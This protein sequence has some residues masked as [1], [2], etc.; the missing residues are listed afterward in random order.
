[1]EIYIKPKKRV[2]LAGVDAVCVSDVADVYAGDGLQK[3]VENIKLLR[4]KKDG[5]FLVASIDVVKAIDAALPGHTV[6]NLGE[7]DCVIEYRCKLPKERSWLLWIKVAVVSMVLFVGASTA[8]MT[9]HNDSEMRK[10]FSRY[11]EII[12]GEENENPYIINIPYSIGLGLGIILFF[13]HFSGKRLSKEPSPI[14][15]EMATYE[16][17]VEDSMIATLERKE[18]KV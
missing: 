17:D 12:F 5:A 1:M 18:D 7:M 15:V 3:R 8:I 9:F 16:K 10:V 11:H 4:P 13:N 2:F 6:N 14:E